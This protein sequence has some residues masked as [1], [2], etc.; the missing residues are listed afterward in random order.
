MAEDLN[1]FVAAAGI[2]PVIDRVL[3]F[4]RARDAYAYLDAGGHF[5]KVAIRLGD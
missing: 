4:D 1:R 2:R 5:G 3:D